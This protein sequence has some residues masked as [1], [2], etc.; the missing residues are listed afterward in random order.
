MSLYHYTSLEAIKS[1]LENKKIWMT[2][3]RYLNDSQELYHGFEVFKM[4]LDMLTKWASS[5]QGYMESAVRTARAS[6]EEQFSLGLTATL[7]LCSLSVRA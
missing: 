3:L 6:F 4:Q 1:V 2:D 5:T 7:F